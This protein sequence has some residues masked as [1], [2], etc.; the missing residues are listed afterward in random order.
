MRASHALCLVAFASLGC[1]Q[2]LAIEDPLPL[3]TDTG[4]EVATDSVADVVAETPTDTPTDTSPTDPIALAEATCAR[5][6]ACSQGVG[7]LD[8]RSCIQAFL[9]SAADRSGHPLGW[10][11]FGC[12][13]DAKTCA[14]ISDC[15]SAATAP[16]ACA[17]VGSGTAKICVGGS[18]VT[19]SSATNVGVEPCAIDGRTCA[20]LSPTNAACVASSDC[21][22]TSPACSGTRLVACDGSLD[23]G[24]DCAKLGGICSAAGDAGTS[25]CTGDEAATCSGDSVTCEGSV[26]KYCRFGRSAAVDCAVL[27]A[28][29]D[30]TKRCA[31]LAADCADTDAPSCSGGSVQY[32]LGGKKRLIACAALGLGACKDTFSLKGASVACA[33]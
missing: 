12:L 33:P 3:E 14:A 13:K 32:C 20:T 19:C 29:C 23:K 22:T 7:A 8:L 6:S 4:G 28:Q 11:G 25:G 15:V 17:A 21:P 1:R 16:T 5:W 27:G 10:S 30:T 31:P 18:V 24:S 26:A 9:A 2:I